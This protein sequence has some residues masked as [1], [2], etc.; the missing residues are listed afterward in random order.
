MEWVTQYRAGVSAHPQGKV[1][2]SAHPQGKVCVSAHP[3][4]KVCVSAHP[5]GK[6]VAGEYLV[7]GCEHPYSGFLV[8]ASPHQEMLLFV[9]PLCCDFE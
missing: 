2:V 1:C 8:L 7:R 5:Q 6:V 3:Q 9:M 4:G